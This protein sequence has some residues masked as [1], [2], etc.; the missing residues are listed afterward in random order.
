MTGTE[1]L[2]VTLTTLQDRV[3][4]ALANTVDRKTRRF[5]GVFAPPGLDSRN[6]LLPLKALAEKRLIALRRIGRTPPSQGRKGS[7]IE[8]QILIE[9]SQVRIVVRDPRSGPQ[10]SMYTP[11]DTEGTEPP[12]GNIA[13]TLER[14]ERHWQGTARS[15][16]FEDHPKAIR[17]E[18]P[19][20]PL[21][22]W[23]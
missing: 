14:W 9:P 18:R 5:H 20:I 1:L 2:S 3:Y 7:I 8:A 6:I 19:L 12:L 15:R 16:R 22:P 13:R 10:R 21:R 11:T 4:S 23:A 17:P